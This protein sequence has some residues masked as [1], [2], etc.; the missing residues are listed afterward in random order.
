[1]RTPLLALSLALVSV[2][3][4]GSSEEAGDNPFLADMADDGKED[5]AYLNP[6]GIEVEVDLEGDVEGPSYRLS[7]GPAVL[8]QFALTYL[9]KRGEVYLESL[10]EDATSDDRSEWLVNGQWVSFSQLPSGA[11]L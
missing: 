9:R 2:G 8:G 4:A 6:D 5:S 7:D 10:A 3:C 1:M 11:T